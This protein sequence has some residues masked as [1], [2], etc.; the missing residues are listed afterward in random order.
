[1]LR[2]TPLRWGMVSLVLHWVAAA[3][4]FF[5]L[6]QGFWMTQFV[7]RETRFDHFSTHAS[8][9]YFLLAL[10]MVRMLWRWASRVPP[11]PAGAPAWER[12]AAQASHVALYLLLLGE[13]YIGWALA[14]TYSQPLDR[15][16]FGLVRFP[17]ISRPGNRDLHETLDGA[18]EAL[19]WVLLALVAVHVTAAFYHWKIRRDDVMQRMLP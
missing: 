19:A 7:P 3:L 9:G 15:T 1:M 12:I 13:S 4:V 16:L 6:A 5:L 17:P 18:H 10:V 11:H 14:G 2:N 8:V